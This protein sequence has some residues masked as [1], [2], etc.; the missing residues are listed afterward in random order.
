MRDLG[1]VQLPI[2]PPEPV[3]RAAYRAQQA[4]FRLPLLGLHQV[5]RRIA[6]PAEPPPD[7]AIAVLE[8]EYYAL[9]TRDLDNVAQGAYPA[10]LL[11]QIPVAR[12]AQRVPGFVLDLPA[13]VRR[14]AEGRYR[15]L[16]E[17]AEPRRYPAYYRRTFHWQTDGYLSDR[18]AALYDLSVEFLFFGCAD[19][20][21]RQVL[22]PLTRYAARRKGPLRLADVACG[23]GRTLHQLARALPGHRYFGID[24]S[25]YYLEEARKLLEPVRGVSLLAENAEALPYR[26]DYFDAMTSVFLFHELPR[27]A[28]RRVAAELA[29]CVRPGGLVVVCDAAQRVEAAD[30]DFFLGAF[31][32]EMHEPFFK[33]Y[34]GDPLEEILGDAGLEVKGT[35]RAWLSKVVVARRPTAA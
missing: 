27:A 17:D 33:D 28:R 29:R 11:F 6:A 14:Y 16:P 24:L 21:R 19:V 3:L 26:D 23:T 12:Y 20:M 10:S 9:L 8:R 25:P 22:P 13:V 32:D 15:D 35:E 1:L 30:L 7:E 2:T 5:L 18:S 34:V 31:A 4:A